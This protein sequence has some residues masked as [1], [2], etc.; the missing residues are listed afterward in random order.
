LTVQESKTAAGRR[1]VDLPSGLLTELWTLLATSA[2]T[3]P[4]DPVFMGRRGTRQTPDNMGR[5]LKSA[6]RKANPVL[7]EAG[8]AAISE[9]VSPH[10]PAAH[11][12]IA[13]L[14]LWG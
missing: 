13:T 1:E 14:R 7:Q 12:R 3:G 4:D 6:I 10:S 9:R 5:R 11:L 8:I 2:H